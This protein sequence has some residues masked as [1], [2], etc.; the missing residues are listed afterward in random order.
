MFFDKRI[1]YAII[2]VMVI[3]GLSS[4]LRNTADLIGLLLTIPGVLIHIS[5]ICTCLCSR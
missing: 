3:S 5:R 2:I 1:L 4:Y